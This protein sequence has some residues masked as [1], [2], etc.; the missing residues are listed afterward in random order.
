VL[1]LVVEPQLG[2]RRK[3]APGVHASL[4]QPRHGGIDVRPILQ[5]VVERWPRKQAALR[6][7]MLVA[8]CVVVGIEQHAKRRMIRPVSGNAFLENERLEEPARVREMPL[9]WTR[10]GH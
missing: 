6:P 5:Y 7:R 9:D 10:V 3:I 2:Q 1:L 4:K 8:Y